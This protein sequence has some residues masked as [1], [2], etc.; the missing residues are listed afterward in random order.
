VP[1]KPGDAAPDFTLTDAAGAEVSLAGFGGR[2]VLVYFYP[3]AT[4]S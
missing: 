1:L 3:T 2:K 4:R